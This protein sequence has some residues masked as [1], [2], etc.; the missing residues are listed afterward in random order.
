MASNI[1][2]ALA[3]VPGFLSGYCEHLF[4]TYR[5]ICELTDVDSEERWS[6][7]RH[8]DTEARSNHTF[9]LRKFMHHLPETDITL[10]Y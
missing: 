2:Q 1:F 8:V 6:R 4:I 3:L 10:T 5:L 9:S 7:E